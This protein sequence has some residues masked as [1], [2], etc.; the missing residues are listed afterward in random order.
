[1][2]GLVGFSELKGSEAL[3]PTVTV[4]RDMAPLTGGAGGGGWGQPELQVI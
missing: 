2:T 4:R 1:M 3:S